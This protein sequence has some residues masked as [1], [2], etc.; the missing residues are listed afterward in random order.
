MLIR[1]GDY[2]GSIQLSDELFAAGLRR[3]DLYNLIAEVP[4]TG[5]VEKAYSALQ[6]AIA[7][8]PQTEDNYGDL[9]SICLD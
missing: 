7:L 8:D 4:G 1:G 2:Q 5:Q 6:S 3:A 9:A